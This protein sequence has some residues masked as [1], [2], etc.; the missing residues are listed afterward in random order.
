MAKQQK[1]WKDARGQEV[2]ASYVSKYD[3]A[4]DAAVAVLR[5]MGIQSITFFPPR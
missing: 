1:V 4:T 3:K 5:G 2:P